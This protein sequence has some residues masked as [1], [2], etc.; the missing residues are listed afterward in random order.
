MA[1]ILKGK[2]VADEIYKDAETRLQRLKDKNIAPCLAVVR[3]GKDESSIAYEDSVKKA[4]GKRGLNVKS[5]ELPEDVSQDRLIELIEKINA[6]KNI[7]GCMVLR[8]LPRGMDENKILN[9]LKSKKDMDCVSRFSL[10]GVFSGDKDCYAPCTAEACMRILNYYNISLKGRRAAVI[11][12]SLVVGRPLAI[13]LQA[14]DA[15]ITMFHSKSENMA[16]ICREQDILISAAGK[17][18]LVKKEFVNE[19][20]IIIDVGINMG[21]DG[22]IHGDVDFSEAEPIVKAISPVPGGVGSV[23]TA[24]LAE[25][26]LIAAERQS[27]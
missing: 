21:E 8:P 14:E 19:N 16:E 22:K 15:T 2:P 13:M 1:I 18:G 25:H 3:V 9:H 20:Q 4:F 27:L 26:L 11:G 23:T 12:R 24:I 17:E 5:C 10:G 7:H 6:D